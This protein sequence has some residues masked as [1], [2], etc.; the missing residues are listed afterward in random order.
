MMEKDPRDPYKVKDGV[1][2]KKAASG[3]YTRKSLKES[4]VSPSHT[5]D[6]LSKLLHSLDRAV[7]TCLSHN[8]PT[9]LTHQAS[10]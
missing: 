10:T 7:T 9:L 1:Q 4:F 5:I 3:I 8:N 6:D 2:K